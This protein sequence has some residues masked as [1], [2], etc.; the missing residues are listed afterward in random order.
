M[1]ISETNNY[2]R[3]ETSTKT[4]R[5]KVSEQI[6]MTKNS[7]ILPQ[8]A[9]NS[10]MSWYIPSEPSYRIVSNDSELKEDVRPP[11]QSSQAS[12]A[13]IR[14]KSVTNQSF[15]WNGYQD[16]SK[17][18]DFSQMY[19]PRP[20]FQDSNLPASQCR[21]IQTGRIL[22][23]DKG[24]Q[25]CDRPQAFFLPLDQTNSD[26]TDVIDLET[27]SKKDFTDLQGA[28]RKNR[29]G[30]CWSFNFLKKTFNFQIISLRLKTGQAE[31]RGG[32]RIRSVVSRS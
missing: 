20:A 25:V 23:A 24:Q 1:K 6:C 22:Q 18:K 7:S 12:Q 29:P 14:A 30:L 9:P 13:N 28:L 17:N 32:R 27:S 3:N 31:C 10:P 15:G 5:R 2:N 26:I 11:A 4:D 21:G 8:S 16:K 19:R